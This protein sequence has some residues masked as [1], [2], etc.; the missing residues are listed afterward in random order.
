LAWCLK[1]PTVSTV[2]LGASK[3]TQLIENLTAI[4]AVQKLDENVMLSIEGIVKNAPR[5]PDY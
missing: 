4:D 1:N 3:T 5:K 2:I